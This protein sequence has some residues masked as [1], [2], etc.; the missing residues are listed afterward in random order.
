MIE[1]ISDSVNVCQSSVFQGESAVKQA[2]N[3]HSY[4]FMGYESWSR[5]FRLAGFKSVLSILTLICSTVKVN[6]ISLFVI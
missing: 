6:T 1:F 4:R 5:Q 3:T 2:S